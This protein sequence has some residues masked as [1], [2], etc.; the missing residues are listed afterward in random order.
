MQLVQQ[1]T[2]S[3]APNMSI[4]NRMTVVVSLHDSWLSPPSLVGNA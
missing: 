4:W 1:P 3:K 2:K